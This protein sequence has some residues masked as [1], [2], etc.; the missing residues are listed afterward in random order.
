MLKNIS[1][2]SFVCLAVIFSVFSA[3]AQT[4]TNSSRSSSYR[5]GGG[6]VLLDA[7]V[8]YGNTQATANPSAG[9][10]WDSTQSIYDIKLGYVSMNR[11]YFGGGVT[12]RSE[13]AS[14]TTS[15]SGTMLGLG[16]FFENRFN[17]RAYYKFNERY[18]DYSNGT[19]FQADLGYLYNVTS[20]FYLGFNMSLRQTT[21]KSNNAITNFDY[22]TRKETYPYL[23]LG[24]LVN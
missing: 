22:W 6:S 20:N 14:G 11:W 16:Y 12:T 24:F 8:Y 19:G 9:N 4:T 18:G 1:I 3:S 13:S 17:I 21:F 2:K 23:A 15:G 7:G 10:V 5:A